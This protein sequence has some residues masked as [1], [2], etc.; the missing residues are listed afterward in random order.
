ML[1]GSLRRFAP[2]AISG[3]FRLV[4]YSDSVAA[5]ANVLTESLGSSSVCAVESVAS[6]AWTQCLDSALLGAHSRCLSNLGAAN[7][8]GNKAG[9]YVDALPP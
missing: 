3:S 1:A 8:N 2:T 5:S 9:W 6:Q 4:Q 7:P